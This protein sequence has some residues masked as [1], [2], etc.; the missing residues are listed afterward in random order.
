VAPLDAHRRTLALTLGWWL[1]RRRLRRRA[2]AAVSGLLAGQGL[3]FAAP[4]RRRWPAALAALALGGGVA[5]V[6]WRRLRG[7]SDDDWGSWEP[8]A[9]VAPVVPEPEPAPSAA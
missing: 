3:S 8:T 1:L 5:Y 6:V 9:P 4:R 7:G 2:K